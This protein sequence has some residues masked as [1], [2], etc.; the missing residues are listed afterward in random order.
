MN[1]WRQKPR[2][3]RSRIW[4]MPE[5]EFKQAAATSVSIAEV[6]S[7]FGLLNQGGNYKTLKARAEF[8]KIDLPTYDPS[9]QTLQARTHNTRSLSEIL[10]KDSTYTNTTS[11]KRRLLKEK[12]LKNVCAVCGQKPIWKKK[13]L[14]LI[15]DHKNGIR[16]DNRLKNLRLVCP[17]CGSQLETH[18]GKNH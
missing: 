15:L 17:N 3:K 6:L 13:I 4:L 10:V 1:E 11:L 18:C 12:L 5:D 7:K 2:V 8:L 14:V 9:N 16:S